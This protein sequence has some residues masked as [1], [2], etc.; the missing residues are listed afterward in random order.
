MDKTL[1]QYLAEHRY[2]LRMTQDAFGAKYGISGPAVFKFEK[3][4]VHLRLA[5][6]FRISQAMGMPERKAVLMHVRYTL[7]SEFH[8]LFNPDS[9]PPAP[10]G[11]TCG[12]LAAT[13]CSRV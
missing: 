9:K 12:G 13:F 3:G 1:G 8:S 5:L 11:E 4:Y 7:P 10:T 2:N 6:W